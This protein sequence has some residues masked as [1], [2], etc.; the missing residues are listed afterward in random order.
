VEIY[1]RT[2]RRF[3]AITGASKFT[4]ITTSN[5][6]VFLS[7][8]VKRDCAPASYNLT[9]QIIKASMNLAV[10]WELIEKNPALRIRKQRI[11]GK[12]ARF[13]DAIQAQALLD[14][15]RLIGPNAHQVVALGIYAG[16]RK[17]EMSNLRYSDIDFDRKVL[18]VTGETK[19]W[20]SRTIGI[21]DK[22]M[23][24]LEAY[25]HV[26]GNDHVLSG[27]GKGAYRC[28]FDVSFKKACAK[29]GVS[30]ATPHT[31][32]H[33]FASLHAIAGTSLFKIS[34]W[35][36]HK[37]YKTTQIY[38]HLAVDDADINRI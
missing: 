38:A 25:R 16:L 33:T 18:T 15:A 17:G 8:M 35:L 23:A 32:R 4:G 28:A 24:V 14:A 34:K 12:P 5:I 2:W 20:E 30:W 9:L 21:N 3:C 6:E 10:E 1:E 19:S 7:D 26:S 11:Q 37:D 13:L 36:G 27:A 22:L 29:A 31:L